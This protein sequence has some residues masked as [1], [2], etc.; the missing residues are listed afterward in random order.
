MSK[1]NLKTKVLKPLKGKD[2]QYPGKYI[3]LPVVGFADQPVW[4]VEVYETQGLLV[5]VTPTDNEERC[6]DGC[7]HTF[8]AV[9]D[10]Q[11]T[12][13][14]KVGDKVYV[15]PGNRV[16]GGEEHFEC[17]IRAKITGIDEKQGYLLKAFKQDLPGVYMYN[18]WDKDLIPRKWGRRLRRMKKQ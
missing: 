12:C 15:N 5:Y 18:I 6:V 1:P 2:I 4:I 17:Y 8:F 7:G 13:D 3:C 9:N 10:I 16:E 11:T 14:F